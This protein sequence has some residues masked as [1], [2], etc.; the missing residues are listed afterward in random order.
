MSWKSVNINFIKTPSITARLTLFYTIATSFLLILTV[1]SLYWV[2]INILYKSEHQLLSDET[3]ILQHIVEN[4]YQ[5][6]PAL[7]Q[8]MQEIPPI[9]DSSVYDH[10]IRILNGKRELVTETEG[11]SKNLQSQ[12]FFDEELTSGVKKSKWWRAPD[13]TDYL[14]MQSAI[15]F[16]KNNLHPWV[17]QIALDVTFQRNIIKKYRTRLI[18][19]LLVGTLFALVLGYVIARRSMRRLYDLTEAAKTITIA[20][21]HKRINPDSWPQ[22]LSALGMAFNAMLDRIENSFSR[23]TQLSADLAHELRTPI[24]NLIGESEV[25]LCRPSSIEEYKQALESNLEEAQRISQIIENLLF[26]ARAENPNLDMKKSWLNVREEMMLVCDFYQAMIDDKNIKIRYTGEGKMN[27]NSDMLRRLFSNLLSNALK[28]T[29]SGG[30]ICFD[31][32]NMSD[33]LQLI[34]SDSGCGMSAEHL[35]KIFN[36]FYRIDGA[37]SQSLGGT[38][39]G[40]AIVKSIVV[41]HRGSIT[42]DSKVGQGTTFTLYFPRE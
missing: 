30:L 34:I 38:G 10:Y 40:L 23:L 22:E 31:I 32:K 25:A 20:S 8:K 9:L 11:M 36:R 16:D 39:L 41:L 13:G 27:A 1:L 12:D 35:P 33:Q 17:I 18:V 19:G 3:E 4:K 37:R 24:N 26:L 2:M 15:S 42:V 6:L 28:Y 14:L 5:D 21:L 7:K 29:D